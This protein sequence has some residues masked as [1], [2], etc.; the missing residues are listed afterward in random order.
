MRKIDIAFVTCCLLLVSTSIYAQST[1]GT[2]LTDWYRHQ[3]HLLS[4]Q[5]SEQLIG[6][7]T[8]M[9]IS[10][11][12]QRG[13]MLKVMESQLVG[14]VLNASNDVNRDIK[15]Y[16]NDYLQRLDETTESLQEEDLIDFVQDL[17]KRQMEIDRRTF[18]I[19]SELLSNHGFDGTTDEV[20]PENNNNNTEEDN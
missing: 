13:Q 5:I 6:M 3:V 8:T 9:Q 17:K 7:L 4:N 1:K 11:D 19:L 16:K 10:V 15:K 18:E 20:S 14:Y 12:A 2:S